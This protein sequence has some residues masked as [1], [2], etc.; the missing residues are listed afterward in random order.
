MRLRRSREDISVLVGE[1][2]YPSL[3]WDLKIRVFLYYQLLSRGK[4][5]KVRNRV[6]KGFQGDRYLLSSP[7]FGPGLSKQLVS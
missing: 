6:L 5:C 3:E 2:P 4:S 7:F 1:S